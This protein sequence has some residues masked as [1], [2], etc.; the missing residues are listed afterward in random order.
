M[1]TTSGKDSALGGITSNVTHI[2]LIKGVTDWRAGT[3]TEADF[4][5]YARKAIT[6]AAAEATSDSTGRQVKNSGAINFDANTGANQDIIG[7]AGYTASTNGTCKFIGLLDSDSPIVG[8]SETTGE[9]ITAP[10]HGLAADQRVFF[11]KAPLGTAMAGPS[12]N[13]AYYVL[14]AGLTT[15]VF[16]ISATSGG[17]AV[18]ITTAGVGWFIPYTAQTVATNAVVSFADGTLIQQI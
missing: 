14:A 4:T 10:A 6:W 17:A 2:A 18:N 13:T 3:V 12:E 8:V 1:F 9:T 5:S 7:Y 16:T 11:M 15:D